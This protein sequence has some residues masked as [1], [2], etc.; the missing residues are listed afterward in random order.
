MV[1]IEEVAATWEHAADLSPDEERA[2]TEVFWGLLRGAPVPVSAV[3]LSLDAAGDVL[4]RLE[5]KRCLR[6]RADGA[7][8]AARGLMVQPS[9]HRLITAQGQVYTQCAVDAIGIPAALGLEG[10][11]EDRCALCGRAVTVMVAP[12]GEVAARPES[13]AIVMVQPACRVEAGIPRM[14]RETNLFCCRDHAAA[15]LREQATLPGA[16]GTPGDAVGVGRS[17]WGRFAREA[18]G[19]DAKSEGGR[20]ALESGV[21]G[22]LTG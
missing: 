17:L 6:R 19:V 10:R 14:C 9:S 4:A 18:C 7:V 11:I 12:W 8:I 1:T 16:I 13:A 21:D 20:E 3:S 2:L 15:W 5:G 22:N